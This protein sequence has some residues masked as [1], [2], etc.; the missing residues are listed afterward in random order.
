MWGS[1]YHE[2]QLA[3]DN[4]V[5]SRLVSLSTIWLQMSWPD[6]LRL[7]DCSRD[8]LKRHCPGRSVSSFLF[9]ISYIIQIWVVTL[10]LILELQRSGRKPLVSTE[11]GRSWGGGAW[12]RRSGLL[13]TTKSSS[14]SQSVVRADSMAR[15]IMAT[16]SESACRSGMVGRSNEGIQHWWVGYR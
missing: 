5:I 14:L 13:M 16:N 3:V 2:L 8:K 4:D 9:N 12:A 11:V 6:I 1:K 7:F 15:K 10:C